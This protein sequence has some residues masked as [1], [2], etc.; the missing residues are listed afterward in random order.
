MF[1]FVIRALCGAG[2]LVALVAEINGSATSRPEEMP[3]QVRPANVT[4]VPIAAVAEP[5]RLEYETDSLYRVYRVTAYCDRGTTA[6]GIPSGAGQCAAP[7]D[8]PFGARIHI[9]ALN[10]TFVVTDRTARRFRHNT[11]D[12]FIPGRDDCLS[13]GCQYLECEITLPVETPRYGSARL[14]S[15]IRS[16]RR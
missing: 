14:S 11:V 4:D 8:I 13:F 3:P 16:V 6:A 12:L 15:A 5:P 7:A 10:R 9:P 1:A 2:I